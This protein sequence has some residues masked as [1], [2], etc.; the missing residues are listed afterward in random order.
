MDLVE[1][2][3]ADATTEVSGLDRW[4]VDVDDAASSGVPHQS[5]QVLILDG[6]EERHVQP[7]DVVDILLYLMIAVIQ[8]LDDQRHRVSVVNPR[9]C[10]CAVMRPGPQPRSATGPASAASTSSAKAASI[11]RPSGLASSP[12]RK[13]SAWSTAMAS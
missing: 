4:A 6:A 2:P 3:A 1:E 8:D 13:R 10:M 5:E 9:A 7:H 12:V 11:A